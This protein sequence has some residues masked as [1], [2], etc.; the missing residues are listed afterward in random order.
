MALSL[1]P[2]ATSSIVESSSYYKDDIK[3]PRRPSLTQDRFLASAKLSESSKVKFETINR[4]DWLTG[5]AGKE[6]VKEQELCSRNASVNI[7]SRA[8]ASSGESAPQV[9]SPDERS[10]DQAVSSGDRSARQAASSGETSTCKTAL[11]GERSVRQKASSGERRARQAL[12]NATQLRPHWY[13]RVNR[14]CSLS[15]FGCDWHYNN[16]MTF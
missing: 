11:S 5:A 9:V 14:S 8:A 4:D 1:E 13:I 10:T 3:P 6:S 16:S 15:L 7:E 2:G 12:A